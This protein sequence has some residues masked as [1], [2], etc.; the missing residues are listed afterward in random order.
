MSQN[1]DDRHDSDDSAGDHGSSM[2]TSS[3]DRTWRC[4][5][6]TAG[7]A[8][9]S[10]PQSK[11]LDCF[12]QS[13]YATHCADPQQVLRHAAIS[14][15]R[16]PEHPYRHHRRSGADLS[17][18]P[19]YYRGIPSPAIVARQEQG[20]GTGCADTPLREWQDGELTLLRYYRE[21]PLLEESLEESMVPSKCSRPTVHHGCWATVALQSDGPQ[22]VRYRFAPSSVDT[23]HDSEEIFACCRD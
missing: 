16:I 1:N 19:A 15:S 6:S 8:P 13:G 2:A 3:T 17:Q 22:Q 21:A 12:D 20:T 5:S 7:D 9:S 11:H 4:W 10:R 18:R 23:S 14:L